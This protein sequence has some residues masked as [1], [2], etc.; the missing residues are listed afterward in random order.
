M[1]PKHIKASEPDRVFDIGRIKIARIG[2]TIYLYNTRR[3]HPLM[4]QKFGTDNDAMVQFTV[5]KNILIDIG[6]QGSLWQRL[7][8]LFRR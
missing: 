4:T 2:S 1:T 5:L 8:E 3:I 7:K 6:K